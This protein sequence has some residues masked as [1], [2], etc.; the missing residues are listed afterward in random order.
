[1]VVYWLIGNCITIQRASNEN[2]D[3]VIITNNLCLILYVVAKV[4]KMYWKTAQQIAGV[5]TE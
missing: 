4:I 2:T 1:M 3:Y 5:A